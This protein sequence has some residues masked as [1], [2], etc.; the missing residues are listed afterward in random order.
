MKYVKLFGI[1]LLF[2]IG[3]TTVLSLV[4]PVKQTIKRSI[5]IKAP[6]SL[7]YEQLRK[8]ENF[9]RWSAWNQHDSTVKHTITGTDGTIGAA[10]SWTGDPDISGKGK[11]EITALEENS[12][13][14]YHIQFI[15]P[16]KGNAE[17]EFTLSE[18]NNITTVNWKFDMAT[19]RPW[20]IFNLF[21]SMDKQMGKDF[22]DGL[23]T[24]KATTEKL[25]GTIEA[26]TYKVGE[27]DFPATSFA[28]IRQ[29][30][31]ISDMSAFFQEHLPILYTEAAMENVSPG[32]ASGLFYLYDEKNQLT[33]MATAL[34]VPPGTKLNNSI[35]QVVDIPASKA[36]YVTYPGAYDNLKDAYASI[37]AYLKENK[38]KQKIPSI[39]QYITGPS[40]EKDP[41]KWVT[42]IVFLV[43]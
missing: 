10:T 31:K 26:K 29:E 21:S 9:N 16:K 37:D 23:Q 11:M 17:S 4:M 5:D 33:D 25:A 41:S 15:E 28:I 2:I 42:K 7:V 1:L 34:P 6:A 22:E 27:M 32:T 36:V 38:L 3:V 8:L 12:K 24:L 18:K 40:S 39:E 13:V 35:I 14:A 30:I 19:A 20:N 43:E